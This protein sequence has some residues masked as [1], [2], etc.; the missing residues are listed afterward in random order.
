MPAS[1]HADQ[2]LTQCMQAG[3]RGY[4]HVA[5]GRRT[6]TSTSLTH[7]YFLFWIDLDSTLDV[8]GRRRLSKREQGGTHVPP[9]F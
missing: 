8:L 5:G 2:C 7:F 6:I 9:C 3:Q 1:Q 4:L